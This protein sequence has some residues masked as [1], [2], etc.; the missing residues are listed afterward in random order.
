M[1]AGL[2]VAGVLLLIIGYAL[3]LSII[4]AVIGI[5]IGIIGFIM[6]LVG[7]F[8]SGAKIVPVAHQL[9]Q[10]V[11]LVRRRFTQSRLPSRRDWNL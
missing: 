6:I 8:T 5:P 1:R 9:S 11:Q 2:I 4:G 7:L 10:L 3:T